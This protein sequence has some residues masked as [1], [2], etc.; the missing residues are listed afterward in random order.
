MFIAPSSIAVLVR[1]HM[2]PDLWAKGMALFT[3]VFAFGQAIG[4]VAAGAIADRRS[5][6]ESLIFGAAL[7]LAA[8]LLALI[9]PATKR[10]TGSQLDSAQK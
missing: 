9:G 1:Q 4:P 2:P 5:L 3:V 6:T 10:P 7:L 8:A